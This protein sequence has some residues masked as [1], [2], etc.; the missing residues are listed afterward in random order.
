MKL[1]HVIPSVDPRGGGPMEGVRQR[2]LQLLQ[3]GHSVEL[4][5][6]DEPSAGYIGD[7]PLPVHALGQG[8]SSYRYNKNL[9]PWLL[10]HAKRYDAVVVNGLWQYHALGTWR[11]MRQLGMPYYVFTHG[12]L[13]PW[14]K[15]T[16]PLKHAKKWL[17]WPWAEYRVLRDAAAVLF[18]SDEERRLARQSFWLYRAREQ[19]VAYGTST[20]PQDAGRLR[21][22]F[23]AQHP[24]LR[25]KRLLLFLGRLH[26]KKGCD[27]LVQA[28]AQVAANDA[29]LHLVM[30]GP[31]DTGLKQGL[32]QRAEALGIA[33]R[34]AW[35]GMVRGDAKWGAFYASEVFVLPSHQEN[36]GISVVEALACGLPVLI[37]DQVNIWREIEADGAGLVAPDTLAGTETLLRNWLALAPSQS[38][39]MRARAQPS[40]AKRFSVQAMAQSLLDVVR[41]QPCAGA[42]L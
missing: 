26:E 15:R 33:S 30:A 27:L 39:A 25:G 1:L 6:L 11:A 4:V 19:V 37:S 9:V 13:D 17:L 23:F 21:E 22:A 36:F 35:I 5:T 34:I 32:Q 42:A 24:Q 10:T 29:S 38:Q 40:Y 12:M 8:L 16:Y 41:H 31:D 7:Y 14:F 28:F 3:W 18:T 20:P 2:G